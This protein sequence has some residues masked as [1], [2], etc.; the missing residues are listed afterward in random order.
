MARSIVVTCKACGY[1]N[2][3]Q[4]GDW[5][6]LATC[7][8]CGERASGLGNKPEPKIKSR[9]QEWPREVR[10]DRGPKS[11]PSGMTLRRSNKPGTTSSDG[12]YRSRP[13]AVP[14]RLELSYKRGL[15][16][17]HVVS[18][19]LLPPVDWRF[20]VTLD[21]AG[22]RVTPTKVEFPR[23]RLRQLRV[24]EYPTSY[25][26]EAELSNDERQDLGLRLEKDTSLFI[27]RTV[28]AELKRKL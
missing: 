18:Q 24:L 4:M 13:E 12:H 15:S 7:P 28:N 25:R 17:S 5:I 14:E 11:A 9:R 1:T 6:A 27:A 23:H 20:S 8:S 19:M 10:L 3:Q 21:S 22:L 16:F 26:V 2:T